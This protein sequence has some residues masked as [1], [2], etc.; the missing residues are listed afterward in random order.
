MIQLLVLKGN[1]KGY[2]HINTETG[3]EYFSMSIKYLD[4]ASDYCYCEGEILS[5]S[6]TVGN[7]VRIVQSGEDL[8]CDIK[9]I[10]IDNKEVEGAVKGQ[11]VGVV[12]NGVAKSDIRY[13]AWLSDF[14]KPLKFSMIVCDEFEINGRGTVLV[15]KVSYGSIRIGDEVTILGPNMEL[16]SVVTG[17]EK[18]RKLFDEAD[19]GEVVGILLRGIHKDALVKNMW[20]VRP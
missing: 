10:V 1:E 13:Y 11:H 6:I 20:L 7:K 18:N 16:H 8:I 9:T 12:L 4:G 3:M 15:G 5:G 17:I 19:K 14:I 2:K